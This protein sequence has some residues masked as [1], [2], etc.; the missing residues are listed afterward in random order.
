MSGVT[1]VTGIW[2]IKRDTLGEGW[3]RSFDHYLNHLESLMRCDSNM[4]IFI[5]PEYE[6]WVWEKRSSENTQVVV[7]DLKWFKQEFFNRIQ[8][9]RKNEK[10]LSQAAW[11]PES[12][13]ARLE[14]YNPIVMSKVFLLNDAKILDKFDSSHLVWVDGG[15]TN[16]VHGGYFWHDKVIPKLEKYFNKF[17]FVAFPYDGKV[18]I[19]GFEYLKM[20]EL[21]GDEVDKVCRG[22]IFGGPK[23]SISEVNGIYYNLMSGTLDQGYMGT[24]ESL[25][26]IMLYQYPEKFQYYEIENNGLLATFF[27]NLK[28]DTLQAKIQQRKD[29]SVEEKVNQHDINNIGLYVLTYNSPEQFETLC[30]SMD[31]YDKSILKKCKKFLINNSTDKST[32]EKY[33]E[34]CKKYSFDM[35]EKDNIGICGGRQFI[36]EHADE[37]GLDYHMFFED[38]M[39]F[40]NGEDITCRNGFVR[41][42]DNFLSKAIYIAWKENLDYLKLN[43]SEF[44]G[45]NQRQ[46]AWHNVPADVRMKL[47][48]ERPVKNE[49]TAN[50]I[51][52][53][54]FEQIRSYSGVGYALGEVYYCNWPQIVSREGNKKMFLETKWGHPFEQTWMS[55]IYQETVKGNIKT[56]ILLATPTEHNRFYHYPG[57]ERREN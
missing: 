53:T 5:E 34:V 50:D 12:T 44:Y 20:C 46:W 33:V 31:L 14:M 38:D 42:I 8:K 2:D 9:I 6:N 35:I 11:L 19:H 43:F 7:R 39:F 24:E 13:Q 57:E 30:K 56:G 49:A 45:D 4:I 16:T 25:F 3:S 1:I 52:Y 36:S 15:L 40:Y 48:P 47:F 51:P 26:T 22:G 32:R 21:A 28:N 29:S 41:K 10:W 17:S 23:D 55:Y 37:I 18:E 54:K 27:E